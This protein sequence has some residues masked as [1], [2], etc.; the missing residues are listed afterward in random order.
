MAMLTDFGHGIDGNL[1]LIY[2]HSAVIW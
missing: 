1:R 2:F